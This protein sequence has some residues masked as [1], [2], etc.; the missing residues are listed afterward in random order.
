MATKLLPES[1]Q[2][3]LREWFVPLLIMGVGG[4]LTWLTYAYLERRAYDFLQVE[5]ERLGGGQ[6][7]ALQ[8]RMDGYLTGLRTM[9][10]YQAASQSISPAEYNL[11]AGHVLLA[12]PGLVYV[13]SVDVRYDAAKKD[14]ASAPA[15][16]HSLDVGGV[17]YASGFDLGSVAAL[18]EALDWARDTG[19]VLA[20]G[21]LR[22]EGPPS[23]FI[24]MPRFQGMGVPVWTGERRAEL[25]GYIVGMVDLRAWVAS[26]LDRLVPSGM[27]LLLYTDRGQGALDTLGF[28][29]SPLRP[30]AIEPPSVA[31]MR[32]GTFLERRLGLPGYSINAIYRPDG[33]S[34]SRQLAQWPVILVGAVI[35]LLLAA[36]M[37]A[38]A[39]R[40]RLIQRTVV[41][42]TRAL[43]EA[44]R[45]L[46]EENTTRQYIEEA[47]RRSEEQVKLALEGA[48]A[49]LWDW[50]ILK[51]DVY[52]S[53]RWESML[54]FEP[55]ELP[56]RRE[57]WESRLHPDEADHVRSLLQEHLQQKTVS[58][59][60]EHRL[61]AKNG[62]WVWILAR[63]KVV[64]RDQQ[65]TALR[66]VGTHI[67]ITARKQSELQLREAKE[68]AEVANRAKSEFLAMMSHEIRTPLNGVMGMLDLLL[69]SPLDEEEREFATTAKASA[70]DLLALLNDILDISKLEAG[71]LELE[72]REFDLDEQISQVLRLL[73]P[74]AQ[75]KGLE[76]TVFLSPQVP[77]KLVGD[78][79]RL[80]Q[81]LFN[82]VG[83]AVKFTAEGGASVT[84]SLNDRGD[85]E[86]EVRFEV[87]DTGPGI[88]R[89][90][91]NK[92]FQ[93]F[94]QAD[95]SISRRH[96]GT[97]LGLAIS[98]RL[99]EL[100]SGEIGLQSEPGLGSRFWFTARFRRLPSNL[101]A[102]P[103]EL[104]RNA[105]II[106]DSAL[107]RETLVRQLSSWGF[108]CR[109]VDGREA[110]D[111]QEQG[112]GVVISDR[113]DL[114]LS[115]EAAQTWILIVN[116]TGSKC[117]LAEERWICLPKPLMPGSFAGRFAESIRIR[118]MTGWMTPIP[119]HRGR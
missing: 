47:L 99:A 55:G 28:R 62:S 86:I 65:G 33:I 56:T 90:A 24:V 103:A 84:A 35:T 30:S 87:S 13:A 95:S 118:L 83:N 6:L 97:G 51:G 34:L 96:G 25:E 60:A 4:L 5:V 50:D 32:E 18:R 57:T 9:L 81:I 29:P 19:E 100:M 48:D 107:V 91:Q 8:G 109:A 38:K 108:S 94:T 36:F 31:Q 74:A 21:G 67:D 40:E 79:G 78:A 14:F 12:N 59:E 75:A 10:A 63:G 20:V 92:L 106:A 46:E 42:R 104:E 77:P 39:G 116:G 26:V 80:R 43:S 37:G 76:L 54:G 119:S 61:R 11:F 70:S 15:I 111:T 112:W 44:N 22:S 1:L 71:K 45:R 115:A 49:A 7:A 23:L 66:A 3:I 102:L 85:D 89:E 2:R 41:E 113:G 73:N 27:D 117:Q 17:G 82:L 64:E 16:T 98:R 114:A 101:P 53:P 88:E 105:L 93:N 110:L 69:D 72:E 52:F 68:L 58:Y